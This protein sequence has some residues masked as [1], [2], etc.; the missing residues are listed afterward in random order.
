MTDCEYCNFKGEIIHEDNILSAALPVN[1]IVP[2]HVIV[3]PKQ[4]LQILEQVSDELAAAMFEMANK[5]SVA[6]FEGLRAQGTNI[7]LMNGIAAGQ[8]IPHISVSIIPRIKDDGLN[9]TWPGRKL[10]DDQMTIIEAQIKDNIINLSIPQ[11]IPEE[12]TIEKEPE[13]EQEKQPEK[14]R[15]DLFERQLR[16]MP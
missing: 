12:K 8:K 7:I 1:P 11:V 6:M 9:Y 13:I 3:F 15:P 4:H 16:R 14:R 2:G 5:L 10:T